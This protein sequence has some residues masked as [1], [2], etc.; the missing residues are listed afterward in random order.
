M[1]SSA[2]SVAQLKLWGEATVRFSRQPD[3][4]EWITATALAAHCRRGMSLPPVIFPFNGHSF[5]VHALKNALLHL[6]RR[7]TAH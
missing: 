7:E 1:G 3:H 2:E 4:G 5:A 6:F